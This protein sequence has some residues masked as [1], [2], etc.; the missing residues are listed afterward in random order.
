M[1]P[2]H[3]RLFN[4]S[5]TISSKASIGA[6]ETNNDNKRF[7]KGKIER[8]TVATVSNQQ[9]TGREEKW[10][11]SFLF[12]LFVAY[13]FVTSESMFSVQPFIFTCSRY[14][15]YAPKNWIVL[16]SKFHIG[17]FFF[18]SKKDV[19]VWLM[20]ATLATINVKWT[21][22]MPLLRCMCMCLL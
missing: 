17:I 16:S 21:S 11:I 10:S 2:R 9:S 6:T 22:T 12:L 3:N 4:T 13:S 20:R 14:V 18:H 8:K 1:Q 19:I 15:Q 5:R 7:Y